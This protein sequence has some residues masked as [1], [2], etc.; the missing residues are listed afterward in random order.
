MSTY[1]W[2]TLTS[3]GLVGVPLLAWLAWERHKRTT[4]ETELASYKAADDQ[5]EAESIKHA[6]DERARTEDQRNSALEQRWAQENDTA[7]KKE[8]TDENAKAAVDRFNAA[9]R[10][11]R[12]DH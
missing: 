2:I 3:V 4:A 6:E 5:A 8:P 7:S 11:L 9:R 1:V 10:R 12:G